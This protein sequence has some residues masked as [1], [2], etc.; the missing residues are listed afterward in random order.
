M[1]RVMSARKETKK[2]VIDLSRL[3]TDNIL[4]VLELYFILLLFVVV[5]EDTTENIWS[6]VGFEVGTFLRQQTERKTK[7]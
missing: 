6:R 3:L 5:K 1:T 7:N 4:L 2:Y